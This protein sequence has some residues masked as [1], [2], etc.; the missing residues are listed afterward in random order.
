[1]LAEVAVVDQEASLLQVVVV[2]EES[3]PTALVALGRLLAVL[4]VWVLV[5]LV[6]LV[7][8]AQRQTLSI[9]GVER[10]VLVLLGSARQAERNTPPRLEGVEV[11]ASIPPW[12]LVGLLLV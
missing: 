2:V 10:E 6:E 1:M 7:S 11:V 12:P 3:S 9:G 8:L 4:E 5:R